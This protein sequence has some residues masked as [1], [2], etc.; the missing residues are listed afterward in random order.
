MSAGRATT[1][2]SRHDV[3]LSRTPGLVRIPLTWWLSTLALP[4][5][6]VVG[7]IARLWTLGAADLWTDE[8]ATVLYASSLTTTYQDTHPPLYYAMMH[9]WLS[10]TMLDERTL[11]FPSAVFGI[12]TI[13]VAYRFAESL[14]DRLTGIVAATVVALSTMHIYYAQEARM[15]SLLTLTATVSA[16]SAFQ[17][18]KQM[19]RRRAVIYALATLV[20]LYTHVFGMMSILAYNAFFLYLVLAARDFGKR[21]IVMWTVTHIGVILGIFPWL[22][23]LA[24]NPGVERIDWIPPVT[25]TDVSS[26]FKEF[27]SG[28]PVIGLLFVCLAFIGCLSVSVR[29]GS[30]G[31]APMPVDGTSWTFPFNGL[32]ARL[33]DHH[34]VVFLLSLI[35]LPVVTAYCLSQ[36]FVPVFVSKYVIASSIPFY[37]LAARGIVRLRPAGVRWA[38]VAGVVLLM[39]TGVRDYLETPHKLPWQ[40]FVRDIAPRVL[41]TD[42]LVFEGFGPDAFDFYAERHQLLTGVQRH[43]VPSKGR[44]VSAEAQAELSTALAGRTRFWLIQA[45]SK[46]DDRRLIEL[47]RRTFV[48]TDDLTLPGIRGRLFRVRR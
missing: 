4:V 39:S 1:L 42:L 19:N 38:T 35:V 32:T 37:I 45:A 6:V 9:A 41:D 24:I 29:S 46:D 43:W 23:Y 15:Y 47:V 12:A 30:H 34:A 14:F 27:S 25:V 3:R 7:S 40:Q 11:R 5:V 8:M 48:L 2:S 17:F 13:P 22:A 31:D 28:S 33:V 26:A 36:V 44:S 18:L 21:E 10:L 16:W 20:L